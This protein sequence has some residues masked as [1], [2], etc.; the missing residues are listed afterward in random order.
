MAD[1]LKEAHDF[2]G[3]KFLAT[4]ADVDRGGRT[5]RVTGG[6]MLSELDE[7]LTD[8]EVKELTVAQLIRPATMDEAHAAAHRYNTAGQSETVAAERQRLSAGDAK[9]AA[10]RAQIIAEHES[11]KADDLA[12]LDEQYAKFRAGVKGPVLTPNVPHTPT[13]NE[14]PPQNG[15]FETDESKTGATDVT[16][17]T[18]ATTITTEDPAL[19]ADAKAKADAEAKEKADVEAKAKAKSTAPTSSSK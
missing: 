15:A 14:E 10:T 17:I 4:H 5:I 9:Y 18:R 16:P 12:E 2:V 19:I 11:N 6:R 1:E 13:S 8:S 3:R 7:P